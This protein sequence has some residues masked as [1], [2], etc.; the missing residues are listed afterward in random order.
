MVNTE[1]DDW[2]MH[3]SRACWQLRSAYNESIK[4]TPF[5]VMTSRKPPTSELSAE[6]A[7]PVTVDD[8]DPNEVAAYVQSIV[9]QLNNI[10]GTVS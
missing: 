3:L 8:H 10:Q 5:E 4:M 1:Q 7:S 9:A 6:E 2:D